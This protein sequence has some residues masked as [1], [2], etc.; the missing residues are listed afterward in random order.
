MGGA[1]SLRAE[2]VGHDFSVVVAV[3]GALCAGKG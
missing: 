3:L 2:P 1:G